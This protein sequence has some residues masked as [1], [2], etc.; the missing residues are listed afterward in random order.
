M[1]GKSLQ[2]T[3][4]YPLVTSFST[5]ETPPVGMQTSFT[6]SFLFHPRQPRTGVPT[7]GPKPT[8]LS[9]KGKDLQPRAIDAIKMVHIFWFWRHFCESSKSYS[10][11]W[12][13]E[14]IQSISES[15]ILKKKTQNYL[16]LCLLFGCARSCW[17]TWDLYIT[18]GTFKCGMQDLQ[19][20]NVGFT[21]TKDW[22]WVLCTGSMAS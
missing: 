13:P 2:R 21:L 1:T 10:W 22:T 15:L 11:S 16:S 8:W 9:S 5:V 19:L 14:M 6:G 3:G 12:S 7:L 18:L 20:Q 4:V 17:G